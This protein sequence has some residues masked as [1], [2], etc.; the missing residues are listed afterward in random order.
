MLSVADVG[1]GTGRLVNGSTSLASP[2]LVRATN[3]ANPSTAFAP[4]TANPV[5]LLSWNSWISNDAVT[6]GLRQRIA[7]NEPLLAGG[8]GKTILLTLSTTTP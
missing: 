5:T 7:Q 1:D 6:I 4:L 8:Y 3:T 2:L